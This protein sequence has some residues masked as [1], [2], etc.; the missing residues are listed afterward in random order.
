M[1]GRTAPEQPS[2]T[3]WSFFGKSPTPP[4]PIQP[5]P[6]ATPN[7]KELG[8]VMKLLSSYE[9]QIIHAPIYE[10]DEAE[11]RGLE[12]KIMKTYPQFID[13]L[14]EIK[15]SPN[16]N[17]GDKITLTPAEIGKQRQNELDERK[18]SLF[19]SRENENDAAQRKKEW[20]ALKGMG[21]S[22]RGKRFRRKWCKS[23][24]R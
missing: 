13:R 20:L 16:Y 12:D 18:L 9:D 11:F 15:K 19:K 22:K 6:N 5:Q 7:I 1:L 8:D 10:T 24:R 21:G 23:R 2:K 17:L 14:N 3:S 4:S